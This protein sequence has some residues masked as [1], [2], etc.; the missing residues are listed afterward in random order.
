MSCRILASNRDEFLNRPSLPA[1]WHSFEPID[2]RGIHT[3]EEEK[4]PEILS[5]RD[6]VAGGTWLGINKRTGKFGILTNVNRQLD[7]AP[8]IWPKVTLAI[9]AMEECLKHS[10]RGPHSDQPVDQTCLEM[11]LFNLLSQTN[12]TTEEVPSNIMVRPHHRHGSEDE[13]ESIETWYGTRTQTVLLVSDTVPSK[14]TLVERDAFQINSSS[15]PSLASPVWVGDDQS[16]WRRFQF[17]L[18]S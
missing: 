18:S 7:D 13:S 10:S 1:H 6:A 5:G 11:D 15:H 8:P 17:F 14:I 9:Y 16:R 2:C 12:E 3:G 4:Q